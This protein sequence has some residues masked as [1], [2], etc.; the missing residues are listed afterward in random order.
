M[1]R[2]F[3]VIADHITLPLLCYCRWG[4]AEQYRPRLCPSQ[5]FATSCALWAE[6]GLHRPFLAKILPRIITGMGEDYPELQSASYNSASRNHDCGRRVD[7]YVHLS[8][9]AIIL[10]QS[11][12]KIAETQENESRGADAFKLKDTYGLPIEEIIFIAKDA[13]S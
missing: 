1:H 10:N 8:A 6:L 2:A 9:E 7:S 13:R 4:A 12:R 11:D 5:N 3:H